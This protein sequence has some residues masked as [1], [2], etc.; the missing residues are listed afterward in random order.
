MRRICILGVAI[1]ALELEQ[2]AELDGRDMEIWAVNEAFKGLPD[3]R[4]PDRIFQLHVRNW[5][6][7]DRSFLYSNGKR[8]PPSMNRNCFGR[9]KAHVEYL[10]TCGVPVYTQKAWEDIPTATVYPFETV[11][12]AVG[13]PLPPDFKKRLWA[14]SSFGYI[15]AL[16]LT[17]HLKGQRVDE[18][19]VL[20][21]ELPMGTQRERLWEWPNF[22]YYLGMMRGMGIH[23]ILPVSGTSLL[24]APHY[25][26]GGHPKPLEADHWLYPGNLGIIEDTLD[27]TWRLGTARLE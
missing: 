26:L 17:E 5:R 2:L 14:T 13:I 3:G 7:A 19:L 16:L 15:G 25:A 23:V 8:L 10:R 22:A 6:E 1:N 24:S 4:I 12:E 20:G 11:Q 21:C 27:G 18:V 9:N